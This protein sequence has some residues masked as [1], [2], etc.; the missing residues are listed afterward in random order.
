MTKFNKEDFT[1][2]GG[3]LMYAG[4]YVGSKTYGEVYGADKCHPSRINMQREAFIARFKYRGIV[5]KA[6]F[7]KELIKNHTVESY[8][9][10]LQDSKCMGPLIVLS[11]ANPAWYEKLV[12]KF[13]VKYGVPS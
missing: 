10:E 3:Y 2:H 9:T 11:D 13:N 7:V 8:L 12:A 4:P 1:Y 5:T 6:A